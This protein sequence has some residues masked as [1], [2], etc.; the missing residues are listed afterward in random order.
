MAKKILVI[1]NKI[2]F[3]SL[4]G[5]ALAIQ[6]LVESL[7]HKKYIIDLICIS[8]N[9]NT[10]SVLKNELLIQDINQI[11]FEKN[12]KINFMSFLKSI[13]YQTSYQAI[14]FY[15]LKIAQEIQRMINENEYHAVIFESVF[16]TIYFDNLKFIKN[17]KIIFRAHNVE[18]KIWEDLARNTIIKKSLF[19]L[20]A[21]QI[22]KMEHR[23]P[24]YVDY[25]FTLSDSDQIYFEKIFPKKT[26]QIPVT[27]NVENTDNL[28]IKNSIAHL[29]SMDW[30]PNIQGINWFLNY[31]KPKL[32]KEDI[33]IY[34]AGK[35]MPT[36]YFKHQDT[37]TIIEGKIDNAKEY[38]KNK[39]IIFVPLFS[40]SGIRIK[41]LEA[42]ALGIPVVSTSKGAEGIPYT[43]KKNIL[44]ANS[45]LEFKKAI[46]LLIKNKK[47]A[48]QIGHQGKQLIL[49]HFSNEIVIKKLRRIL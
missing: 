24:K 23:I 28:K 13:L 15:D 3:P 14:R 42:M 30:K 9:N 5:G 26:L 33:N 22:K 6:K 31:V 44:I 21:Q 11:T 25:I 35:N 41:I 19:L 29:G 39:E 10:S 45:P 20:L 8:K 32:Q 40:G 48:Q 4:D 34:I 38:I 2:V 43:N 37:K 49:R 12:M 16:T 46:C 27:F 18:H 1:A 36:K 17:E 7:S 47:L